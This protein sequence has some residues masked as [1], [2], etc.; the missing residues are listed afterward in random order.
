MR[1]AAGSIV[2]LAL[3]AGTAHAGGEAGFLVVDSTIVKPIGEEGRVSN[4]LGYGAELRMLDQREVLTMSIGGYFAIGEQD[5]GKTM[6]DLYD[7]HFDI[8]LKPE[9]TQ[10]DMVIPFLTIGLDVLAMT[11][12]EPKGEVLRGT[13]LGLNATAG[14][15]GHIGDKWL[16]RANVAYLGAIV[17]GTGDDLGGVV[18]QVGIGRAI[19]D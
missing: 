8:G 19:F 15:M 11:T 2:A 13:T 10:G 7:F 5:G 14:L 3:A 17:P 18:L 12:R 9:R 6:R 16:Y 1:R 4:S